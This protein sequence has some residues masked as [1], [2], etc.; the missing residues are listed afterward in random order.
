MTPNPQNRVAGAIIIWAVLAGASTASAQGTPN[1]SAAPGAA[2]SAAA[3]PPDLRPPAQERFK[4]FAAAAA[5]P[6]VTVETVGWAAIAQMRDEPVEWGQDAKGYGKRFA[7]LMAQG[8]VQESVT[9]GLSEAM[10]V[11]S[12]FHKSRRHGFFPRAGDALMQAVTSR[13]QDGRR[14]LSAPLLAGYSAGGLA[15]LSWYPDRYDYHDGLRYAGLAV[16]M[17]GGINLVREFIAPR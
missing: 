8:A 10:K 15:M 9:Y 11:D 1:D 14:I 13:R 6:V 3:Q 12:T 17:R 16:V 2:P 5:G 4:R 7:S